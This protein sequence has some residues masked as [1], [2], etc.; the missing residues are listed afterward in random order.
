MLKLRHNSH[1]VAD[2]LC[3]CSTAWP[4]FELP[5]GLER[6]KSF[7][8]SAT[9]ELFFVNCLGQVTVS[10]PVWPSYFIPSHL[11]SSPPEKVKHGYFAE[12]Y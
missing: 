7:S 4:V 2:N 6:L 5:E 12:L 8:K 1:V 10:P 3:R 9:T 11:L